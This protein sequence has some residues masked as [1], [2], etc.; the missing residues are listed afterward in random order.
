VQNVTVEE[1]QAVINGNYESTDE[2]GKYE[3]REEQKIALNKPTCDS[4]MV[5]LRRRK[6]TCGIVLCVLV[7]H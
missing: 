2:N 5:R 7:K 3:P 1:I 4:K 6:N